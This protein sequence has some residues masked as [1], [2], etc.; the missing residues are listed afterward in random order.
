MS[1]FEDFEQMY[2]PPEKCEE[3]GDKAINAYDGFLPPELL[4]IWR[5]PHPI[6][7]HQESLSY[8]D[9]IGSIQLPHSHH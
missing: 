1:H 7:I 8:A 2:A 5:D 6:L 4:D 3:P 9:Q